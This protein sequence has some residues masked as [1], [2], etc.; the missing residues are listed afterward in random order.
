MR[1]HPSQPLL[2][3]PQVVETMMS[4]G[5]GNFSHQT[6]CIWSFSVSGFSRIPLSFTLCIIGDLQGISYAAYLWGRSQAHPTLLKIS[7]SRSGP[8]MYT[9]VVVVEVL[10]LRF[11]IYLWIQYYFCETQYRRKS[12]GFN[13]VT[14]GSKTKEAPLLIDHPPLHSTKHTHTHTH[15]HRLSV[16]NRAALIIRYRKCSS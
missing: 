4:L 10:Y 9:C 6:P 2:G 11:Q 7:D 13:Q 14:H 8:F 12:E 16:K 5:M 1:C 15:T 3:K